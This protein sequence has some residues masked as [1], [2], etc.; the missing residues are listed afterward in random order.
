MDRRTRWIIRGALALA[1]IAGGTAI[2]VARGGGDDEPLIGSALERAT[3]A[4]LEHTGGGTVVETEVGDDGA[5]YGVEIRLGDGS[6]VEVSLDE[7]FNVIGDEG[8]DD[9]RGDQ[10]GPGDD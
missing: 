8:D 10:D 1:L 4:A 9:G 7:N 2:A 3:A 6:V 5:A